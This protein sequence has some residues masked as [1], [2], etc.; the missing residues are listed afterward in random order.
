M[1]N[2]VLSRWECM[3]VAYVYESFGSPSRFSFL[4]SIRFDFLADVQRL[5]SIFCCIFF[6][7]AGTGVALKMQ[8]KSSLHQFNSRVFF[9]PG[10][11]RKLY[12]IYLFFCWLVLSTTVAVATAA[13]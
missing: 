12:F 1:V 13:A 10:C 6:F 3:C 4:C 9:F 7:S 11:K 5:V 8:T 2:G